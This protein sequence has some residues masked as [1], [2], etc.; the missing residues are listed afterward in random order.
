MDTLLTDL[1]PLLRDIDD[2]MDESEEIGFRGGSTQRRLT[3][4][5][6]MQR[7]KPALR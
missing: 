4:D 1:V 7:S 2:A 6:A 5:D 3:C